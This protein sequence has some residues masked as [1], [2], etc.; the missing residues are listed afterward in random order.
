MIKRR[1]YGAVLNYRLGLW[2]SSLAAASADC[3]RRKSSKSNV[4]DDPV[5]PSFIYLKPL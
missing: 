3:V 4:L 5:Q 1:R 2:K